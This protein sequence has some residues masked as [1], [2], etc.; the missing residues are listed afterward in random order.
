MRHL[1]HGAADTGPARPNWDAPSNR[2]TVKKTF[3]PW[4][5]A[6]RPAPVGSP[7]PAPCLFQ[8]FPP[9]SPSPSQHDRPLLTSPAAP[10]PALDA[11]EHA[12]AGALCGHGCP[13][14]AA[15]PS[16]LRAQITRCNFAYVPAHKYV[17]APALHRILLDSAVSSQRHRAHGM[18]PHRAD[19]LPSPELPT[20]FT[21][22][23]TRAHAMHT[24]PCKEPSRAL[25][26][27]RTVQTT[28]KST[29]A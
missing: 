18:F 7:R 2:A 1:P 9:P 16:Y 15:V 23:A 4:L 28:K 26:A 21:N 6:V 29:A 25:P 12:R 17:Q 10:S 8:Q 13:Y 22:Q 20:L 19:T 14:L 24:P 5:G 27:V 11:L 3:S